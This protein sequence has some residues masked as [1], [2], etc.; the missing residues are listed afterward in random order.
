MAS[1]K[2]NK[3]EMVTMQDFPE[4]YIRSGRARKLPLH[5]CLL[6]KDWEASGLATVFVVRR[7][8]NG[9]DTGAAFYVDMLCRGLRECV[10][11]FFMPEEEYRKMMEEHQT[12]VEME[13]ADYGLA[14]SLI[15]GA[16]AY[17]ERHGL[18]C[19]KDFN[20]SR[21]I[22][23]PP[24]AVF[25]PELSFGYKGKPLLVVN[26]QDN[27]GT[28]QGIMAKLEKTAGPGNYRVI[29]PGD[30]D[31]RDED[32]S[33]GNGRESLV[34][35]LVSEENLKDFASGEKIPNPAQGFC[36]ADV[37]HG[38]RVPGELEQLDDEMTGVV[39]ILDDMDSG[40]RGAWPLF[41]GDRKASRSAA[42]RLGDHWF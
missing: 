34:G 16:A 38:R 26:Q 33:V 19:S 37:M 23:E 5:E 35:S 4:N 30:D 31:E 42:Y 36:L 9:H 41:Y 12:D 18:A 29:F 27:E 39:D 11:F 17:A 28:V 24:E 40:L 32:E 14:H 22:L 20:A 13:S 7:Y 6:K 1:R 15:Y 21:Y 10:S 8:V 3:A 25:L 2:K